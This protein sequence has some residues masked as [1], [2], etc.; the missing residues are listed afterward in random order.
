MYVQMQVLNLCLLSLSSTVG[1][2]AYSWYWPHQR[3]N[4]RTT[5]LKEYGKPFAKIPDTFMYHAFV[6]TCRIFNVLGTSLKSLWLSCGSLEVKHDPDIIR[7]ADGTWQTGHFLEFDSNQ[8]GYILYSLGSC[9]IYIDDDIIF[10]ESFGT[11]IATNWQM[12]QDSVSLC[13]VKSVPPMTD[14]T[15]EQTG[16]IE[17]FPI[18]TD[19]ENIIPNTTGPTATNDDNKDDNVPDLLNTDDD[20][21]VSSSGSGSGSD[22]DED[23]IDDDEDI[24]DIEASNS[25]IENAEAETSVPPRSSTRVQ[26]PKS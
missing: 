17:N 7:K 1:L 16:S 15:I 10:D 3:N 5:S 8:K 21:S 11:A 13:L 20:S 18:I 6:H 12:R 4:I 22:S 19:E 26:K 23:K 14:A 2:L 9:Q 25:N 24:L